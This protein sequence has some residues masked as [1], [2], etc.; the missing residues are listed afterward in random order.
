MGIASTTARANDHVEAD[1]VHTIY[2]EALGKGGVWGLGYDL[3]ISE[4][5]AAGI[6]GSY[7]MLDGQH[8]FTASP[9]LSYVPIGV[10]HRWFIDA[11]PQVIYTNTPSPVP[12]WTGTS[13]AGIGA[14]LSSGYELRGQHLM[15]RAY[16]MGVVGKSGVAPWFGT[17]LGWAL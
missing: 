17:S 11:G 13:D 2:V 1:H 15:F 3:R 9:Y 12:E 10:R 14:Q 7:T 6:V 4:R 5:L 16:A 8:L